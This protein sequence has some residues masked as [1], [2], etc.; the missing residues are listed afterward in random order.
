MIRARTQKML[1]MLIPALAA[2]PRDLGG[3]GKEGELVARFLLVVK[4]RI[5]N[6]DS[7]VEEEEDETAVVLTAFEVTIVDG[8]TMVV[9]LS[10][11]PSRRRA[12][13]PH[14]RG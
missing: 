5:V 9:A 7:V 4:G 6:V 11:P 13:R 1:P 3:D 2:T 8:D 14:V 12:E 10:S